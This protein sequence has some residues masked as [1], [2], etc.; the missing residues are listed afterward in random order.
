MERLNQR[1]PKWK[2]IP[3]GFTNNTSIGS[4]GCTITC[5]AMLAG[6]TPDYVNTRLKAVNGF[7]KGNL[8]IWS[9]IPQA[10]PN[11]EFIR[12]VKGYVNADV[13]AN[14]PCMVEVDFDGTP[15]T[16]DMHWVLFIGNKRMNDPWTGREESTSKYPVRGYS[17]IR[18][19]HDG[20]ILSEVK[21]SE[22]A[23]TAPVEAPSTVHPEV[24]PQP[25]DFP[26]PVNDTPDLAQSPNPIPTGD[27]TPAIIT[28][29]TTDTVISIKDEEVGQTSATPPP[30][31]PDPLTKFFNWLLSF[32][33]KRKK[34][35]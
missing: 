31:Q 23:P 8:V 34:V 1:D 29:N 24:S 33:P 3:L 5:I 28:T 10:L 19:K 14:L 12:R 6:V 16:N 7:D 32:L 4:H 9:K 20:I 27:P 13:A 2:N 26:P 17:V 15:N 30:V 11:L 21:I 35:I 25:P 22:P 18:K